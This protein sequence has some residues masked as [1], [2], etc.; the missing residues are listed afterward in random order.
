M[1]NTILEP[2]K[3]A[4]SLADY[5][6]NCGDYTPEQMKWRKTLACAAALIMGDNYVQKVSVAGS[7]SYWTADDLLGLAD[8]LQWDI[9][10]ANEGGDEE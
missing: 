5:A 7:G 1:A 8:D 2:D 10:H 3:L 4:K 6:V 9:D